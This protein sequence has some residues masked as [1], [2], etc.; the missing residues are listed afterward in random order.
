M[1]QG[2][3]AFK[4]QKEATASGMTA[5]AG[6]PLSVEL[7]QVAGLP[8]AIRR[9]VQARAGGQGWDDAPVILALVLL[10]LAGGE[11]VEDL[12]VLEKD[13]GLCTV[14][15]KVETAGL[16]RR[17]RDSLAQRWRQVRRRTVPS[18]WAVFRYLAGFH[19]P[20]EEARRQAHTAFI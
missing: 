11:A 18:P 13:A 2:V 19:D 10:N 14:L 1:R 20:E 15:R 7:A 3:L 16:S 17:A 5:L 4:Y 8:Q 6:L 12:G 9:H